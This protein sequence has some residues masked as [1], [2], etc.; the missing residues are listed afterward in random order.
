[1]SFFI[2]IILLIIAFYWFSHIKKTSA[3][4][5]LQ[6][7]SDLIASD[8]TSELQD[9]TTSATGPNEKLNEKI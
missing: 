9:T 5:H 6:H 2:V 3:P 1:M 7:N 4:R 8:S